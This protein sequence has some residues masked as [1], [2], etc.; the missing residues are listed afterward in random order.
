M[1]LAGGSARNQGC[2]PVH[3]RSKCNSGGRQNLVRGSHSTTFRVAGWRTSLEP[4]ALL[5][6]STS[7]RGAS[8]R[9][10]ALY[11]FAIPDAYVVGYGLDYAERYRN[12][13]DICVIGIPD[14]PCEVERALGGPF[15]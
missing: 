10:G 7:L 11:R 13:P 3:D 15:L 9:P 1:G 5:R 8:N 4:C 2:R 14:G 6:C 12:L